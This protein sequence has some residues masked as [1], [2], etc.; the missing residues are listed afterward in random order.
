M[1]KYEKADVSEQELEDLVRRHSGLI[2]EGLTYM[3]HQKQA[4]GGRLDVLMVDSGKALVVAELKVTQDDGMLLQGL[5][6]YDYV[7]THV[8][9]YARLYNSHS[10]DPTQPVRLVLVA[11]SFSQT[12]VN[13]CK[14]LNLAVALFTYSCVKFEGDNETVILFNEREVA[15][16]PDPVEV[17]HLDDHLNYITDPAVRSQVVALLEEIKQWVP[18]H[19]SVD[20]IKYSLSLKVNGRL[21]AFG[22]RARGL[23]GR[24]LHVRGRNEAGASETDFAA[25]TPLPTQSV[26]DRVAGAAGSCNR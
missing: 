5:D 14:W 18:G 24:L 9:A 13:R 8:E 15:A 7:S 3:D 10:V 22:D 17:T 26:S 21:F 2:E 11:P 16:P 1:K 19:I 6:Y 23:A 20:P 4:A 25:I 12:L